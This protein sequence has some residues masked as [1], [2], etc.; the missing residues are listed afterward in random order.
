MEIAYALRPAGAGP[1]EVPDEAGFWHSSIERELDTLQEFEPDILVLSDPSTDRDSHIFATGRYVPRF[2][3]RL[4]GR[5]REFPGAAVN[6]YFES[7]LPR[8][9]EAFG[10]PFCR[11]FVSVDG[12]E[13]AFWAQD[14]AKSLDTSPVEGLAWEVVEAY[15]SMGEVVISPGMGVSA[16]ILRG[17][18]RIV[19][20]Y[21]PASLGK[22]LFEGRG[23]RDEARAVWKV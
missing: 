13:G 16:L 20:P 6:T 2:V 23:Y 1:L 9:L 7:E 10:L 14:M 21:T 19:E 11:V 18:V 3:E 22:Y 17:A 8:Y 15:S 5:A 4:G 12:R